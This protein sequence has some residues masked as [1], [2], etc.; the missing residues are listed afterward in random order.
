MISWI[1]K[2]FQKH[3][4]WLF[5]LLLGC[6]IISFVFITNASSGFGSAGP[7]RLSRPFFGYDLEREEDQR[8]IVDDANYSVFLKAG[9]PF[10]QGAQLEQYAMQR[11]AALALADQLKLPPPTEAQVSTYVA[12]LPAFHNEQG[13]FDATKYQKFGDSLKGNPR[14]T[15]AD[16]ARVM[17]DDVRVEALQKLLSGPGYVLPH[18]IREELINADSSWTIQVASADYAGF[19]PEIAV[20]EDALARFYQ[21]NSFRYQVPERRRLSLVEFKSA[22][23]AS[24]G[25]PTEE[26][27]RAFYNQNPARFPAPAEAGKD[28]PTL[29]PGAPTDDFPKVRAQVEAALR[30]EVSAANA[31]RAANAV[32]VALYEATAANKNVDVAAAVASRGLRPVAVAPFSPETP[33]AGLEWTQGYFDEISRL[34]ADRRFSDA[35]RTPA[36]YAVFLWHETLPPYQPGLADVRAR[37]E[38]DFR[39]SEKSKRFAEHGRALKSRLEAALKA[40][41]PFEKAAADA[42]LEV[43]SHANFTFQAPPAGLPAPV[44]QTLLTLPAGSVTDMVRTRENK[45]LLVYLQ[46]RKAPDTTSANPRFAEARAR[47]AQ[48]G[49]AAT[50]NAILADMIAAERQK[51]E[52]EPAEATP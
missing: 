36:G 27:L 15:T 37:V 13:Q 51:S 39:E 18:E 17:R 38:T 12:G 50:G 29:T 2:Y 4:Q 45:G 46:E 26:Q 1:Q 25:A 7:K 23:F 43:T 10:M 6:T 44:F 52:P 41:T 5:L 9:Y 34:G 21:E 8:R 22:D 47:L 31:A 11:I 32:T 24:P 19:A 35:L 14:F 49:V 16:A 42:K 33:P 3:F 48:F 40:G 20:T 28:A 30:E